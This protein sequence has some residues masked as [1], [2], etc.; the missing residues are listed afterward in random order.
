MYKYGTILIFIYVSLAT[1]ASEKSLYAQTHR[2]FIENKGQII[3]Q[4]HAL[5]SL[6]VEYTRDEFVQFLGIIVSGEQGECV[7]GEVPS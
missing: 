5:G 3:D 1:L 7:R 2:A 4:S 6:F